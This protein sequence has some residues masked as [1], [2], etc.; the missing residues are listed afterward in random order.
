PI[1]YDGLFRALPFDNLLRVIELS[2]KDV[3]TLY[4][5]ALSGSHGVVGLSG[6]EVELLPFDSRGE[7]RDLN[8]DGKTEG[9]EVRRLQ[10][11]RIAGGGAI[12]DGKIYRVATFDYLVSGGDDLAW[13]MGRIPARAVSRKYSGFCR[14]LV[15]EHLK[16]VK[17]INTPEHPLVDPKA[18]RIRFVRGTNRD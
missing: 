12:E 11:I 5:I 13:F 4:E 6:L 18:P 10:A 14:D 8:G 1:T 15:S 9:W 7:K 2:G 16:R 3:K 17:V